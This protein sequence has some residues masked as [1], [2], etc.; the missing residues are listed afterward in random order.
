MEWKSGALVGEIVCEVEKTVRSYR[1]AACLTANLPADTV[2]NLEKGRLKFLYPDEELIGQLVLMGAP[3][4]FIEQTRASAVRNADFELFE[5]N[6]IVVT[7]FH[8][9]STQW[10]TRGMDG[11]LQGLDYGVLPWVMRMCGV[12]QKQHGHV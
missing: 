3:D 2:M 10:R 8:R 1:N 11:A 7:V 12:K 9:M 4:E 5:D 6:V